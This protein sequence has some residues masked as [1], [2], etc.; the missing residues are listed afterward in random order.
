LGVR[1]RLASCALLALAQC[2]CGDEPAGGAPG[3]QR[4][5]L[6]TGEARFEHV[7][8]EPELPLVAGAQGG[9]HV[10]ASFLAYGFDTPTIDLTLTTLVDGADENLVMRA[11]LTTREVIDPEGLPART[12]A[13]FPAQVRD[14]RCADGQRVRLQLHVAAPGGE[15]SASDERQCIVLLDPEFQLDDCR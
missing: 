4:V 11:R 6:G 10:W 8:G 12:F 1:R 14:A 15:P 7:E 2:A 3:A 9:F 13:G 5:V